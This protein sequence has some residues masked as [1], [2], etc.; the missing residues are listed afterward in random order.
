MN[1][2]LAEYEENP[3]VNNFDFKLESKVAEFIGLYTKDKVISKNYM[4]PNLLELNDLY[5]DT[6][7]RHIKC[8][9]TDFESTFSESFIFTI[10]FVD[11]ENY[12]VRQFVGTRV[13]HRHLLEYTDI[14][15]GEKIVDAKL[16]DWAKS[17][18]RG[19]MSR[20]RMGQTDDQPYM[21]PPGVSGV[22]DVR[23]LDDGPHHYSGIIPTPY[24]RQNHRS[25]LLFQQFEEAAR[26]DLREYNEQQA[27]NDS[28]RLNAAHMPGIGVI[29]E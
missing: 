15:D 28:R 23:Q 13:I 12:D 16:V 3:V 11:D 24:P 8:E 25:S 6:E 17:L 14:V 2:H 4:Q 5:I 9:D 22:I 21:Y 19:E 10:D 26:N 20:Q 18:R 1:F 7:N 29:D 27:V